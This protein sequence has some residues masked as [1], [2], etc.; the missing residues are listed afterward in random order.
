MTCF[1]TVCVNCEIK[2]FCFP[3]LTL[4]LDQLDYS[5]SV[6]PTG[7]VICH[8]SSVYSWLKT[9]HHRSHLGFIGAIT[10]PMCL[11]ASTICKCLSESCSKLLQFWQINHVMATHQ[12][13]CH[14]TSPV[15]LIYLL[16]GAQVDFLQ[17]FDSVDISSYYS[18]Q[19]GGIS[20]HF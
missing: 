2:W 8:K 3:E 15:S 10:S 6:S 18:R 13:T 7:W 4:V 9:P 14:R 16:A 5:N 17:S 19:T 20:W 12:V 11:S 1:H